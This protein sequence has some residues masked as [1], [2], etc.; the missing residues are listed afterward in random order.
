MFARASLP[1]LPIY[2]QHAPMA[3]AFLAQDTQYLGT[4]GNSCRGP[5]THEHLACDRCFLKMRNVL[6]ESEN[7]AS[8]GARRLPPSDQ[9]SQMFLKIF[10]SD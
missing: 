8:T 9:F 6:F 1:Y 4:C 7:L 3:C 10:K 2:N 5:V